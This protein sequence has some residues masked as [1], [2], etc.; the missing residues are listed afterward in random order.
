M[1]RPAGSDLRRTAIQAASA[2]LVN[3]HL[4]GWLDGSL[5]QGRLKSFCIPGLHCYSCPSSI[6]ACPV[7]TVQNMLSAPGAA[8]GLSSL[9]SDLLT[10]LGVL[11]FVLLPG[12]VA[13]RIACSHVCPFGLLQD[14]LHLVP[15]RRI[16]IPPAL[17]RARYAVLAVFVLLLPLLLRADPSA[18]GDPWFCKAVCPSGTITAGW[19]LA[20]FDGG[21]TMRLGFLFGW[22]SLVALLLIA[23]SIFSWRPFCRVLCP[24]GAVW[25]LAGKVSVVRMRVADGCIRCGACRAVCPSELDIWRDP[26]S[27]GCIRC[28]RCIPACPVGVI[29]HGAGR[30]RDARTTR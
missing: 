23:W 13:G 3:L 21:E 7:G 29:S 10:L 20:A 15:A 12:F 14:A 30:G 8:A 18:G 22:K 2:I 19:P 5:Y 11:G 26:A 9:G 27:T 17:G 28:G 16:G 6:L 1:R 25:G 4:S 24:L